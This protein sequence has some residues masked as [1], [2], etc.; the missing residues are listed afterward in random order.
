ML[1]TGVGV[2]LP[3]NIH[4]AVG[5]L[6]SIDTVTPIADEAKKVE[7]N[8]LDHAVADCKISRLRESW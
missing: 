8:L 4:A 2:G 1:T 5:H 3:I 6:V 7:F